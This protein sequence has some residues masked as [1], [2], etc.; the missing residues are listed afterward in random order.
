[1][2]LQATKLVTID[3]GSKNDIFQTPVFIETRPKPTPASVS[4]VLPSGSG[5]LFPWDWLA[6]KSV[7]GSRNFYLQPQEMETLASPPPPRQEDPGA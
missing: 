4:R 7:S 6:L 2:L 1:M 3:Y 5:E